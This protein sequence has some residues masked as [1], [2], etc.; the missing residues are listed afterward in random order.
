M[1]WFFIA[2]ILLI[3]VGVGCLLYARSFPIYSDPGIPERLSNELQSLPRET[4]FKEW[5]SR[6]QSFETPYK[7]FSDIGRGLIA[8]GIALLASTGL[9]FAY[10]HWHHVRTVAAIFAIWLVLWLG[11]IPFI[12]WY[13]GVREERFDYPVWGDSIGLPIVTE[14][15]ACFIGA[16]LSSIL[17]LVLLNR[18]SLPAT[19]RLQW[20]LSA[21]GWL[22]AAFIGIWIVI[23]FVN[24]VC[25]VID[26]NEGL[27]LSCAVAT[28]ILMA[29]LSASRLPGPTNSKTPLPAIDPR[30]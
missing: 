29:F 25:G 9:W 7:H 12:M 5:Y 28:V 23:L 30:S 14:S 13:Y 3:A 21:Y 6:L 11:R 15:G 17:L 2:A 24:V 18:Y 22:R 27:V 8:A 4:R 10:H 16:V 26:G 20:P 1:R 19:I